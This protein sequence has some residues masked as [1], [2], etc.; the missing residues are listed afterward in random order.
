MEQWRDEA[1]QLEPPGGL[2]VAVLALNSHLS[3]SM[4]GSLQPAPP[5]AEAG[6]CSVYVCSIAGKW[7][8]VGKGFAIDGLE[9]TEKARE[10]KSRHLGLECGSWAYD[11]FLSCPES[12]P[13]VCRFVHF[14][15]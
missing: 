9:G 5:Q 6:V 15:G 8:G 10:G 12:P 7:E 11:S 14:Q 13:H 2:R 3:K 1:A 4:E